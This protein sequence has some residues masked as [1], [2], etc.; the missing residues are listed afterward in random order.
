PFVITGSNGYINA[1]IVSI[2]PTPT[3]TPIPGYS[4]SGDVWIDKY[5]ERM[6]MP[7]YFDTGSLWG[8]DDPPAYESIVALMSQSGEVLQVTKTSKN[9]SYVFTGLTPGIYVISFTLH[10]GFEFVAKPPLPYDER[11]WADPA[12]GAT[13]PITVTS[14]VGQIGAAIIRLPITTKWLPYGFFLPNTI[15]DTSA[16]W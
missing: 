7:G 5:I 16:N 6:G 8:E 13:D 15:R 1:G 2:S 12:T 9:G 4:L 3:P 11:T 14:N 10:S